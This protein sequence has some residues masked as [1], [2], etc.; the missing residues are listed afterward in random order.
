MLHGW[1]FQERDHYYL[2]EY[3]LPQLPIAF[4]RSSD[5]RSLRP[6]WEALDDYKTRRRSLREPRI[7]KEELAT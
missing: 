6:R 1:S 5:L 7:K 2:P 3:I 4:D